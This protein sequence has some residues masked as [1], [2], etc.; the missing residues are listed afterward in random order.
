LGLEKM[1][2]I[3][4]MNPYNRN[5]VRLVVN[6]FP[7]NAASYLEDRLSALAGDVSRVADAALEEGCS[8]AV[9]SAVHLTATGK[10]ADHFA[11]AFCELI[12]RITRCEGVTLFWVDE[13]EDRLEVAGTTGIE[14][15]VDDCRRYYKKNEG[16]TGTVWARAK[17]KLSHS[18]LCEPERV[19]KS[20]EI[21]SEPPRS[22]PW[23][24]LFGFNGDV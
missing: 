9:A 19:G 3:P 18:A 11:N 23:E 5:H 14:W 12:K 13:A 17:T 22:C 1:I 10:D 8:E 2:S 4:L 16:V 7:K 24:P 6:V 21:T 20:S 15:Y